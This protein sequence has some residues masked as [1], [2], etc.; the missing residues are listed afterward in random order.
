MSIQIGIAPDSWGVWFSQ[1]EKQPPW[2]QCLDEMQ[3]AGYAGVELG[4]W[5]YLPN[6]P[7]EL[8]KE[9]EIRRL[10]LIA[11]TVAGNFLDDGATEPL[12]AQIDK[13]AALLKGFPSARYMVL[14]PA[15]YTDEETGRLLCSPELTDA[16]WAQYA[17]NVQTAVDCI[18]RNG[19]TAAFHPHADSHV[20]TE[21]QIERLLKETTTSL[22]LDTG[23]HV[24]GG[25]EPV[26]F[27]RKHADRIPFLHVKDC[28]M[29]V[30]RKK[31]AQGWSFARAV[32]EGIMVEPGSGGIDYTA[33]RSA[34]ESCGY[35]G[36][37]VV[38]QDLFPL[39]SFDIPFPIA[40]RSFQK[41]KA[42]GF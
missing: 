31:D 36:W 13:I 3:A 11:G 39:A 30:K 7:A 25:G 2:D 22:C 19:L 6:D 28:D 8:K 42:A 20:Q 38:E 9:L 4:P 33:L 37:V 27:Y 18:H 15:M 16:Q 29:V 41:L 5:G 21:A 10:Q 23:H 32:A 24:Y 35:A 26:S 14:L 1:H 12:C 34:L 17:R 40:K